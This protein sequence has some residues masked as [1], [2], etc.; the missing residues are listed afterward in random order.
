MTIKI[1]MEVP[2]EKPR[3]FNADL[4]LEVLQSHKKNGLSNVEIH[5]K[6]GVALRRCRE[7]TQKLKEQGVLVEKQCRC[8]R[9]P[10]YHLK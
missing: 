5:Q 7:E 6:S 8:Q 4:V 1:T 9:T 3:K 2:D 10:I